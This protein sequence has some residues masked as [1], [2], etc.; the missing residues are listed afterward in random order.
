MSNSQMCLNAGMC[1]L[2]LILCF[3]AALLLAMRLILLLALFLP[4]TCPQ[5]WYKC[6][7][8][9]SEKAHL[10]EH[11]KKDHLVTK[12]RGKVRLPVCT[13]SQ[14][15]HCVVCFGCIAWWWARPFS[16]VGEFYSAASP[17]STSIAHF[18]FQL[19]CGIRGCYETGSADKVG[20]MH[21]SATSLDAPRE[22]A[23]NLHSHT[24]AHTHA[25]TRTHTHTQTY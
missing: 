4:P 6:D 20:A 8:T 5:S 22:R 24:R 7:H 17:P 12:R 15:M 16:C 18:N 3:F 13:T 14:S 23:R 2:P 9:Y 19:R 25:H 10:L 1:L 11:I 21:S